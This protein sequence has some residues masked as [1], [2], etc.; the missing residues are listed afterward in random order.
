MRNSTNGRAAASGARTRL[1]RTWTGSSASSESTLH[2]LSPYIGKTKSSMAGSLVL[3]FTRPGDLVYDPFCGSGTIALESWI[4]DRPVIAGDLSPYAYLLTRAKL[5][6]YTSADAAM[7]D[8]EKAAITVK[9]RRREADLRT[10]PRWVRR[11]FHAETL[12]DVVAWTTGLRQRR[13]HF[14]MACLLGILHH[15]R[16]GFLSFP[17][18]HTVPY[19]RLKKF[20]P[21]RFPELYAYRSVRE[22]LEAKV[23]RALHRVP[24]LDFGIRR[25]CFLRDSSHFMPSRPVDA[26]ITSPPYMRQLDY[27]RDN[28]LRLWFLGTPDWDGLDKRVSPGEVDFLGLMRRSF[29][30]WRSVLKRGG[31]CVLVIGDACSRIQRG[32]LPEL[33]SRMATEHVG[34]YSLLYQHT[35]SIP[36]ERRVRRHIRGS[37]SET[38]LVLR[39]S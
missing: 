25:E 8:I 2:Q 7:R 36:N 33:V 3:Q 21:A 13:L 31:V 29:L 18:S 12:R 39:R 6:P 11:F 28:R 14:L 38:V 32:D 10:V 37:M 19:L 26:I 9:A 4:G 20:P 27:G 15:Q 30:L 1:A 23:R 34:G 16:P 35:E 5:F 24:P 22:R 17:S